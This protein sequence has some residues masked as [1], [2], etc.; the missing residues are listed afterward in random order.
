MSGVAHGIEMVITWGRQHC[1]Q[2][3]V[4]ALEG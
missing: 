1:F 4:R 3:L 2:A